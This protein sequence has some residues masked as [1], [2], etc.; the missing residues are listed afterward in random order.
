MRNPP[1]SRMLGAIGLVLVVVATVLWLR[2]ALAQNL[3]PP[4]ATVPVP[5]SPNP[6]KT[7]DP[8][9]MAPAYGP[10]LSPGGAAPS[11]ASGAP[12]AMTGPAVGPGTAGASPPAMYETPQEAYARWWQDRPRL[13]QTEALRAEIDALIEQETYTR[14]LMSDY[15]RLEDDNERAAIVR[16]LT[17]VIGK[18]FDIR[19]NVRERELERLEA[20]IRTLREIH[21][22]RARLRDEI[23]QERVRQLLRDLDGLGWGADGLD[24]ELRREPAAGGPMGAMGGMGMPR[25][26]MAAPSSSMSSGGS[27]MMP[28]NMMG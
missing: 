8:G 15:S 1:N 4:A 9:P 27:G 22:K 10:G 6:P 20:Q 19:Q 25:P 3:A 14:R 28:T 5:V 18:H 17:R 11:A 16:E 23:I 2:I 12:A 26:S 21:Q 13:P 7:Y 24:L